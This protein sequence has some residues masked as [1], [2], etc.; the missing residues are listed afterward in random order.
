MPAQV[1]A[2]H[3][4]GV[5]D[6]RERPLHVLPAPPQPPLPAPAAHPPPIA[7]HGPLRVGGCRPLAPASIRL[8]DVGPDPDGVQIEQGLIAVIALIGDERGDRPP[9]RPCRPGRPPV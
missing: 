9:P 3:P 4:A 7:V 8:R 5:V 1:R 6:V 2:A